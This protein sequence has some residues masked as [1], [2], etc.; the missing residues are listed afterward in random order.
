M[1]SVLLITRSLPLLAVLLLLPAGPMFSKDGAKTD[2]GKE[3]IEMKDGEDTGPVEENESVPAPDGKKRDAGTKDEARG[4]TGGGEDTLS[5]DKPAQFKFKGQVKNLYLFHRTDNFMGENPLTMS[6]KNL[7]ADLTRV[8]LS[9]EFQY[10]E[11]LTVKV[12]LDNE[13]FYSNYGK[14]RDFTSY[15]RPSGYNDFLD[16]T[17]EPYRGPDV[18]YR[19]KINRAYVKLS[20]DKFTATVG[21]QQIRFG[22]GKLWNP[23]DIL[24]PVSPTFV[25]GGDEQ[26]G[27]DAVK[28]DF[29]PEDKTEITAVVDFKKSA[30]QIEH[31]NMQ[32]CNYIGRVK[33]SVKDADIAVLGGYVARRGVA[34]F[35]FAAIL[36][37]GMLRGSVLAYKPEKESIFFQANAGYEY[38]F[39]AG[40]YIL[41]EYLFNQK[42]IN[43][44][45]DLKAAV[46]RQQACMTN[47]STYFQLANQLLTVNQH[48]LA[49][50][51]GYDFHPLVRGELFT[52][53]D[54]QGRGIFWGPTLRIN[55]YENLDFAVG[56][57]GAFTFNDR[58]SDF[59]EF[60]KNYLFY[61]SGSYVF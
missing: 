61:A 5:E 3:V 13:L 9:P 19:I 42:A 46:F 7:S 12:D 21:R 27:T 10:K 22:S 38:T 55:A 32:D 20:V 53:G 57:M 23:L 40:V 50:A 49:L 30:N 45:D 39:K 60:R 33:T 58:S 1:K 54:I 26:K 31:F 4:E 59:S 17:W 15:W 48:Y 41:G 44:N 6:S 8:R 52:I 18:M 36:F 29:Y 35:D 51:L 25:E 14:S 28:L 16:L 11:L 37:G 34:G 43:Y 47:Q 2:S 24:N 56:M